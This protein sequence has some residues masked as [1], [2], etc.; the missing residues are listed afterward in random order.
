M[1]ANDPGAPGRVFTVAVSFTAGDGVELWVAHFARREDAARA[2][3]QKAT[4]CGYAA[5]EQDFDSALSTGAALC[6][7]GDGGADH[8]FARCERVRAAYAKDDLAWR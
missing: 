5:T 7:S 4:E 8:V 1:S 2:F 6:P 3:V